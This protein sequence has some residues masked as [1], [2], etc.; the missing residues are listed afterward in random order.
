MR[1]SIIVAGKTRN[2][3]AF[4]QRGRLGDCGSQQDFDGCTE[5]IRA[6]QHLKFNDKCFTSIG[7]IVRM[8][9]TILKFIQVFDQ[10]LADFSSLFDFLDKGCHMRGL[11]Q[12]V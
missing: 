10:F 2:C 4:L 7:G 9:E 6:R 11:G 12:I 1:V 3:A 8:A 5:S